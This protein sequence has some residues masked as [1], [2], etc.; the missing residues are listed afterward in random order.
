MTGQL[1]DTP[2]SWTPCQH[3]QGLLPDTPSVLQSDGL[4]NDVKR[5]KSSGWNNSIQP[6]SKMVHTCMY[7][8]SNTYK[9]NWCPELLWIT[10]KS[11]Y[12]AWALITEIQFKLRNIP[13]NRK[14]V[15]WLEKVAKSY[16][17]WDLSLF[18]N[19]LVLPRCIWGAAP[20]L[21]NF[22]RS[23]IKSRPRIPEDVAIFQLWN[24]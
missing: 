23:D 7:I 5:N 24:S 9:I 4:A 8:S 13:N 20:Y 2:Q 21:H 14:E 15:S 17:A 22:G 11:D 16:N 3:Q 18:Y 12:T 19:Y 6:Y 1:P 10:R